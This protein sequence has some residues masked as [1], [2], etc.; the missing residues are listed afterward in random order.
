MNTEEKSILSSL[1]VDLARIQLR[2]SD[3][4]LK[5][6]IQKSIEKVA[7]LIENATDDREYRR[8]IPTSGKPHFADKDLIKR[9][10][11]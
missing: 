2:T 6:E 9:G 5:T 3:P 11:A 4:L 10:R 1:L 8:E 7:T